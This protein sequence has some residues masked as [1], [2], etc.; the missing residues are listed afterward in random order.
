MLISSA[1]ILVL[2]N[3]EAIDYS[4]SQLGLIGLENFTNTFERKESTGKLPSILT[5][6]INNLTLHSP[7]QNT[8]SNTN[9]NNSIKSI[10]M[11]KKPTVYYP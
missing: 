1:S 2:I 5:I 6:F 9:K 8:K 4:K 3:N 7:S 11:Q 10:Q